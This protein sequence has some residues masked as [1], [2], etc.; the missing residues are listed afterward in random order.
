LSRPDYKRHSYSSH[1]CSNYTEVEEGFEGLNKCLA[2]NSCIEGVAK[3]KTHHIQTHLLSLFYG[4]LHDN[5][6]MNPHRL[7]EEVYLD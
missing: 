3:A 4:H 6:A 2:S 5:V 1:N 7:D